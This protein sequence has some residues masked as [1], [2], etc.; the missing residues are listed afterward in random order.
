MA[1]CVKN[2]GKTATEKA[3]SLFVFQN[4]SKSLQPRSRVYDAQSRSPVET[5]YLSK[6]LIVFKLH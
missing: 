3:L 2:D 1:F 6:Q 5:G 4:K